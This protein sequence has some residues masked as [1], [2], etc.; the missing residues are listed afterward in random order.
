MP[1]PTKTREGDQPLP[2]PGRE[3]VQDTLIQLIQERRDLGVQRYGS[4]LMTHNGRDAGRDALEEALDLTVYL[5]QARMEAAD[6]KTELEQLRAARDR[7]IKQ[8]ELY[9]DAAAHGLGTPTTVNCREVINLLSLTW[10]DGKAPSEA[11]TTAAEI[12]WTG[13]N[14]DAVMAFMRPTEPVHVNSLSHMRFTN[15][16][17]LV[18]LWTPKGLEVANKGDWIVRGNDGEL[19]IRKNPETPH[20]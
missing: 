10:P 2:T 3:C 11:R 14:I 7:T 17:D 16:D 12:Q 13:D 20:A 15:A 1:D 6:A 4:A 8:M 19:S 9:L 5:M 18:G